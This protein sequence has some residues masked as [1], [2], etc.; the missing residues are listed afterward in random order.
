MSML[1]VEADFG[2]RAPVDPD[3]DLVLNLASGDEGAMRLLAQAK[4]H[5]LISLSRRML[6]D[7]V[8]AEDV[9]QEV[10]LRAWR[11]APT[12]RPGAG[13][14]ETWMHRVAL[15]L[16][17]DRLR[18]RREQLLEL[19]PDRPDPSPGAEAQLEASEV[20]LRVRGAINALPP[21]QCEAV[22]LCCLGE[23]SNV[24]AARRMDL[25]VEAVESLLARARR[26]L[27]RALVELAP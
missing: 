10:L 19:L 21:R 27:K 13:R 12:W 14:F 11:Q 20:S 24:E 5:K 7:P 22:S 17:Y 4:R 15:N 9:A 1:A 18:R 26:N 16:C 3:A 8:E 23:I 6:S 2:P 25:T